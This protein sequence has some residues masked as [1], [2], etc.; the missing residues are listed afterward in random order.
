MPNDRQLIDALCR[1]HIGWSTSK[2]GD[3]EDYQ[4]AHKVVHAHAETVSGS[5]RVPT[6]VERLRA[7]A[8]NIADDDATGK[9]G[10]WAREAMGAISK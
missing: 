4:A 7:L 6:E 3:G 2:L 8:R 10:R 5:F 1:L 9:Y